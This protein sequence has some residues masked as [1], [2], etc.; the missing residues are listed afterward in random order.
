[1]QPQEAVGSTLAGEVQ[2]V[3]NYPKAEEKGDS[4]S[5]GPGTKAEKLAYIVSPSLFSSFPPPSSLYMLTEY[6]LH[7]GLFS[8]SVVSDSL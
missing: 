8:C 7:N 5:K 1:M 3:I 6:P 2:M 4:R